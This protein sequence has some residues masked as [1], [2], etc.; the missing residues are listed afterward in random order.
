MKTCSPAV[1]DRRE[2]LGR[3]VKDMAAIERKLDELQ[4]F[5]PDLANL[6]AGASFEGQPEL[7]TGMENLILSL[8][9]EAA[10]ETGFAMKK[11]QIMAA[12]VELREKYSEFSA[13]EIRSIM[14]QSLSAQARKNLL[15]RFADAHAM[16]RRMAE[17]QH[18]WNA[19]FRNE[20]CARIEAQIKTP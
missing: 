5:A 8:T 12:Y 10:S 16:T 1:Q 14:E 13:T 15:P 20:T 2:L 11:L 4:A 3:F 19:A 6:Y 18:D 9:H 7:A 17:L